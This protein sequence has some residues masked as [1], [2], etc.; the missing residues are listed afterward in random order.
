MTDAGQ[1]AG[2]SLV[3]R[4][5]VATL[6]AAVVGY[7]V[8]KLSCLLVPAGVIPQGFGEQWAAMSRDPLLLKSQ[9]PHR[10]L[11]PLLAWCLGFGGDRYCD[12][13]QW[14][15]VLLLA[16]VFQ[17]ARR[18]GARIGDAVLITAAVSVTATIQIYKLRLCGY[19][20][21]LGYSLF[22]IGF[23]V[24]RHG[25]AFW[26]VW[27]LN[28][29]NHDL[30]LFFLPWLWFVR[31]NAGA[32]WRVD[33]IAVPVVLLCYWLYRSW[34]SAHAP[35]WQYDAQFFKD[36]TYLPFAFTMLWLMAGVHLLVRFG[37]LLVVL[38][39]HGCAP[40]PDR[41]RWHTLLVA[42]GSLSIFGFAY[43]VF[44]HSNMVFVPLIIASVRFLR[45]GRTRAIYL[46]LV[47]ASA[48]AATTSVS[49]LDNVFDVT[50][51]TVTFECKAY[52]L[53][54]PDNRFAIGRHLGVW[55]CAISHL[56][57]KFL[58]LLALAVAFVLGGRW[59]ARRVPG[60]GPAP[61]TLGPPPSA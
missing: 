20:D 47:A 8:W 18:L 4:A 30:A 23:L 44:R 51:S 27:L 40:R 14:C 28:L 38:V 56:W 12:F 52:E 49:G 31:R 1:R 24:A 54:Y 41:D 5:L 9:F 43:D 35:N 22:L 21:N 46:G 45:D 53:V 42:V 48:V 36:N 16:L 50:S 26:P 34:I 60:P 19:C 32:S 29:T 55:W 11:T 33:A 59:L 10:L 2:E 13:T 6:L 17:V 58:W 39:W 57:P 37:A 15:G 7:G 25:W 3:K 61:V